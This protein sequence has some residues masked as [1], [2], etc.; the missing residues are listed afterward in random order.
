MCL[1][2][3][4]YALACLYLCTYVWVCGGYRLASK[5]FSTLFFELKSSLNLELIKSA[6]LSGHKLQGFFSLPPQC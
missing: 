6:S 2:V 1:H 3:Q 4:V 5:S